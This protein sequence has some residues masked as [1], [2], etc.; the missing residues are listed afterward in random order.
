[1]ATDA[2]VL[3]ASE[4]RGV[5]EVVAA[6]LLNDD[7]RFLL[8]QRPPGK[9]YAG[10]WEFPGGKVESGESRTDAL[11]RE[12][13]EELGIT[14][15]L[16]YP[17]ITQT[18]LYPHAHVRLHFFRV[19][20]WDGEFHPH[21]GQAFEWQRCGHLTVSPV[22]PANGPV[23]RALGLP[24]VYGISCANTLGTE[25]FLSQL[26]A[27]LDR[28][29]RLVQLR[30]KEL[31]VSDVEALG[32]K[33]A[34]RCHRAGAKLLA[35]GSESLAQRIGADGV[36]LPAAQLMALSSRP[37]VELCGASCHNRRELEQA[38]RLEMD[39]VV[40]GSVHPTPLH[41]GVAT[42]GWGGFAR[43]A[44]AYPLPT[45]ALGG[46]QSDDLITA[47]EHGAHGIAMMRGAWHAD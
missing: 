24:P 22:L 41:P 45:F 6:V 34:A 39:F 8:A 32:R 1:V 19:T 3:A 5:T 31:D 23:L 20:R 38:V 21:E 43:L 10:Y 25:A 9:A 27:A 35:N 44:K 26:D 4:Q 13:N 12:L 37:E 42:L 14:L 47:W 36:H 33:V 17:W 30:E 7:G 40:L 11:R 2:S 16:A 28:G 15:R 18:Y 29:L 46:V